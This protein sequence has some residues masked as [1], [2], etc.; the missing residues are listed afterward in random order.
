MGGNF[1]MTEFQAAV[2]LAQFERYPE[3]KKKREK[4]AQFL[5]EHLSQIEGIEVMK[6]DPRI[7]SNSIHL[8]IWRYKKEHFNNLPK[9]KFIE[10]LQKEGIILSAGYSIP[11]YTQPLFKNLA[12]GPK[13]KKVDLGVDYNSNYL[14]ETERACYE[15]AL[16][17]PQFVMLGNEDDMKDIVDAVVKVKE[18]INELKA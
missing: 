10:A 15:E 11:L 4:N 12:F 3:L 7:T 9:A 14:P 18:N 17:L 1:R 8:F 6:N 13:G 2:L 5:S 16:W